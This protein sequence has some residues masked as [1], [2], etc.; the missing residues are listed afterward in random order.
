[1]PIFYPLDLRGYQLDFQIS[2]IQSIPPRISDFSFG[3]IIQPFDFDVSY[4]HEGSLIA[5]LDVLLTIIILSIVVVKS[6][7]GIK[8]QITVIDKEEL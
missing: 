4:D 6:L 5:T 1:M 8:N 7:Q 3:F 2:I